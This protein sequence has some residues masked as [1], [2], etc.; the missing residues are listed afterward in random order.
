MRTPNSRHFDHWIRQDFKH[1]NTE[2]ELAYREAGCKDSVTDVGDALKQQLLREGNQ[3]ITALLREGN[4]DEGFDNGF[5]LLGNVGFFMAACRRHDLTEPSREHKS[6]LTD[7]SALAMQLGASLGVIPRF[8]SAHLETH[9]RAIN[10]EYKSFTNLP[11]EHL[12]L[13]YNTRGVFAFI[14]ASEALLHCLP[15]GV[16]HPVT[17]DLLVA[18][19]HDLKTVISNN[20]ALFEKLDIDQFFYCVRPYYKTHRVG[21]HEYRGANAGDF[22]GINV[23][24]LLLGLCRAD[25]PYYSQLLVDKFLFMRPDDQL[26]LRDCMRRKSLLDG[27]LEVDDNATQDDWFQRNAEAFLQVCEL[28]GQTALQHHELLIKK[29]IELPAARDGL[30]KQSDL[31]ASGPPLDVMLKGLKKLCDLRTAANVEGLSTRFND[32]QKLR[33]VVKH[34]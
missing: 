22:A 26:A 13:E 15:L 12:F 1:I 30:E 2:L 27:F 20:N 7:A 23:I 33:S 8:A 3:H 25:D 28:H 4:T 5:D 31:T 6:P 11:D 10:G 16:S 24:D 9:N 17:H 21:L 14:R 18:A 34:G 32:L 29:F 19:Q